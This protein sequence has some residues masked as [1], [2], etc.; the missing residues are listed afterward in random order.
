MTRVTRRFSF[1]DR[2]AN[3]RMPF[4]LASFIAVFAIAFAVPLSASAEENQSVVPMEVKNLSKATGIAA[5]G[6]FGLAVRKDGKVMAWGYSSYGEIGEA[7]G[8]GSAEA[9]E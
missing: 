8:R 6:L 2:L 7:N 4:C 3:H 5:G 9:V 1:R